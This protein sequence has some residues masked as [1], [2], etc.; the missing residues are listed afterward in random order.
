MSLTPEDP[1]RTV[2]RGPWIER[3]AASTSTGSLSTRLLAAMG[4]W[5]SPAGALPRA[6]IA[7][8]SASAVVRAAYAS[9]SPLR[10]HRVGSRG[11]E[12]ALAAGLGLGVE[13]RRVA[14][15]LGQAALRVRLGLGQEL[16][17]VPI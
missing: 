13:P 11:A 3:E 17:R 14:R 16:G 2:R 6:L 8:A 5:F 9:P 12:L 15:R 7:S 10:L 4:S 1:L